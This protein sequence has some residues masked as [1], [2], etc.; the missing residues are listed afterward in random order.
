MKRLEDLGTSIRLSIVNPN[1][2]SNSVFGKGI[3]TLCKGVQDK[4]SLNAS[5]KE[6]GMAYSKAW[7]I[8]KETESALGFQLLDRDG[9]HGSSLTKEGARL[10]D[11][12]ESIEKEVAEESLKLYKELAK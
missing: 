2:K 10:L 7:R 1:S 11:I 12:Y 9:A 5:A 4:G 8:I 3:C 6:I